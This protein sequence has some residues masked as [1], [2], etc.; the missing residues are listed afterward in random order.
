M[1]ECSDR[2]SVK[3]LR[4]I[5]DHCNPYHVQLRNLRQ[6]GQ[7]TAAISGRKSNGMRGVRVHDFVI[8]HL[9]SY[10]GYE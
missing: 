7:F 4:A 6:I 1:S 9:V 3:E 2:V 8:G 5:K 10:A